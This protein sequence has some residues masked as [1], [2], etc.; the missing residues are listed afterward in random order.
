MEKETEPN[1]KEQQR[2]ANVFEYVSRF[3]VFTCDIV[4]PLLMEAYMS[5][6]GWRNESWK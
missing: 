3:R 6:T 1:P 4:K 5:M 2:R